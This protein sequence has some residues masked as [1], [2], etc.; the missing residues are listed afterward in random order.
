MTATLDKPLTCWHL[1]ASNWLS[2]KHRASCSTDAFSIPQKGDTSAAYTRT[3]T[4]RRVRTVTRKESPRRPQGK[5]S[6][7]WCVGNRAGRARRRQSV[8]VRGRGRSGRLPRS[9]QSTLGPA[10]A[11]ASHGVACRSGERWWTCRPTRRKLA[12]GAGARQGAKTPHVRL[13]TAVHA[14]RAAG[15]RRDCALATP[16]GRRT[17]VV[18]VALLHVAAWSLAV[19][20]TVR[21]SNSP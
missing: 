20:H 21:S 11:R 9:S 16:L 4:G 1:R 12:A 18:I 6:S 2:L 7:V 13:D 15:H 5:G 14:R 3:E 8:V 17:F 10:S 19:S